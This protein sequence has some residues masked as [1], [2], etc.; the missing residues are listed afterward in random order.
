MQIRDYERMLSLDLSHL[1]FET[2]NGA[3]FAELAL[4]IA[5]NCP[6]DLKR[7]QILNMLRIAWALLTFG[8]NDEFDALMDELHTMLD[9]GSQVLPYRSDRNTDSQL[10][11]EWMLLSSFRSFP[12]LIGDDSRCEA[13]RGV[14]LGDRCS[15]VILPTATLVL[16]QLFPVD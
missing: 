10:L 5:K 7:Q 13:S 2:I 15:Q 16:R 9:T 4:D 1:T 11:G 14:L 6:S 8:I 3:P 12:R